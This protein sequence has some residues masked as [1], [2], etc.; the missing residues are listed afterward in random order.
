MRFEADAVEGENVR[1]PQQ[2]LLFRL[3]AERVNNAGKSR[4][5][6]LHSEQLGGH[7]GT[8]PLDLVHVG[9]G[10]LPD[11]VLVSVV[12]DVGRPDVSLEQLGSFLVPPEGEGDSTEQREEKHERNAPRDHVGRQPA[13]VLQFGRRDRPRL[14]VVGKGQQKVERIDRVRA[15][16]I[17]HNQHH[18]HRRA[19]ED[20][21]QDRLD[22]RHSDVFDRPRRQQLGDLGEAHF[23]CAGLP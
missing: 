14:V 8:V 4:I 18:R 9:K 2:G 3:F 22:Q 12:Q 1:V 11:K 5:P 20:E 17:R 16:G 15:I 7:L 19:D 10:A 6:G 21:E 13:D 23:V